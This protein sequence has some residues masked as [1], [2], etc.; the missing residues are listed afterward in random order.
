MAGKNDDNEFVV[1]MALI[2]VVCSWYGAS[3]FGSYTNTNFLNVF[4]SAG[5]LTLVRYIG[6]VLAG[7]AFTFSRKLLDSS[8]WF[9]VAPSACLLLVANF[10]MSMALAFSGITLC[11]VVKATIPIWTVVICYIQGDRFPLMVYVSLAVT[12][13]GVAVASWS[14]NDFTPLGFACGLTSALFQTFMNVFTKGKMKSLPLSGPE[15][16]FIMVCVCTSILLPA[17]FIFD[18]PLDLI[19]G[20]MT[21]THYLAMAYCGF[22]YHVEYASSFS[23]IPMVPPVYYSLMDIVRR[24]SIILVGSVIFNKPIAL[25]NWAGIFLAFGGIFAFNH[26]NKKPKEDKK[27]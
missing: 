7:F 21:Q 27:A 3:W 22:A 1:S 11:S 18:N 20:E 10:A 13:F 5:A 25:M 4:G 15:G 17:Q 14:D 12:V 24:L 6:S 16:Q 26:F 2:Q 9:A 19:K 8:L 23:I